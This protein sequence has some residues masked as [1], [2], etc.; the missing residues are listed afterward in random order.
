MAARVDRRDDYG[1]L[2]ARGD[3]V[4]DIEDVEDI[5][6]WRSEIK[7]QAR[8]D[9]I[10]VRTGTNDR[11]AWAILVRG[12]PPGWQADVRRYHALLSRVVPLAVGHGHEPSVVIRDR[13]EVICACDR[14]DAFGYGDVAD[15]VSGG[16]LF[17]DDC[18]HDAPGKLTGLAMMFAPPSGNR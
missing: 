4:H 3:V 5:E 18:P 1:R 7:R 16:T 13:D 17:A 9:R 8:A 14:C 10:K 11:I 12:E 6:A 2:L 15:D